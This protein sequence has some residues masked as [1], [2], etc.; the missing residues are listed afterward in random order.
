MEA[1]APP[2][3]VGSFT[4]FKWHRTD[5]LAGVMLFC[6]PNE[7]Y[8]VLPIT[9]EI[10]VVPVSSVALVVTPVKLNTPLSKPTCS[11]PAL[12][13]RAPG[14]FSVTGTEKLCRALP[15]SLPTKASKLRTSNTPLS[16]MNPPASVACTR[17]VPCVDG[18]NVE[19]VMVPTVGLVR[20]KVYGA[21]PPPALHG[22]ASPITSTPFSGDTVMV[23]SGF[24][25]TD[26][27]VSVRPGEP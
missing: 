20:P 14:L 27:L 15:W 24:T 18:V 16:P 11:S 19:P 26:P 4:K 2:L 8:S 25:C 12:N 6:V 21:V 3:H 1:F 22:T 7:M 17:V 10:N 9:F 23:G 13:A 5:P